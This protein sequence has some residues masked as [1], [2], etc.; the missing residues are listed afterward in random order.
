MVQIPVLLDKSFAGILE[1][2]AS[3]VSWQEL[4][5]HCD[6]DEGDAA[7]LLRKTLDLVSQVEFYPIDCSQNSL[8]FVGLCYSSLVGHEKLA[9]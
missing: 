6:M 2:W 4:I 9:L 8:L 1:A 5:E 7:R 3:G